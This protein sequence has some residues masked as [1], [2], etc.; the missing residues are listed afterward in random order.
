[1]QFTEPSRQGVFLKRYKRFFA[2]VQL[3]DNVVVAHVPNTGSL[4]SC[5]FE[6]SACVVTDSQNPNRKL[7]ATLQ[8]LETPTGWVGVNTA[9]ANDLVFEAWQA[10][11]VKDW[12]HLKAA[13]R[14]Y[15]ISKESRLDFA[16]A[17]N[18]SAL[19]EGKKLTFVEVKNVSM[20]ENEIAKF[21]DA[22]TTRGQKHLLDLIELKENGH[23]AEIVF[24]IQRQNCQAFAP[25]DQIDPEYGKLLRAAIKQGVIARAFACDIEPEHGIALN[26]K[27]VRIK[28]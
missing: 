17:E 28:L 23:N 9:L 22:V 19:L 5:M 8:L 10:K 26:P 16:F 20:F 3:G 12:R 24:L 11:I 1:M 25:A 18:E 15:K 7:K 27:P 14:E 21:P 2:D 4:K 13:K 6:N